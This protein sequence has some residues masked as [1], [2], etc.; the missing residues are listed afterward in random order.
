MD[1]CSQTISY[2]EN[3][4]KYMKWDLKKFCERDFFIFKEEGE[5]YRFTLINFYFCS[6]V[7]PSFW[8]KGL[9][10][11][12]IIQCIKIVLSYNFSFYWHIKNASKGLGFNSFLMGINTNFKSTLVVWQRMTE[13]HLKQSLK[14][15]P[16]AKYTECAIKK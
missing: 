13:I 15:Q 16:L 4:H 12:L 10:K 14:N 9:E 11:Q 8:V 5:W 3:L 7:Q 1:L 6:T 2:L